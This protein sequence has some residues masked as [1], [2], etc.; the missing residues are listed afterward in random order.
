MHE[1][2]AVGRKL[3]YVIILSVF[4]H[5]YN[6]QLARA[7]LNKWLFIVT[8]SHFQFWVSGG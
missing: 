5:H 4:W 6:L 3:P 8:A 7:P 1:F 2:I